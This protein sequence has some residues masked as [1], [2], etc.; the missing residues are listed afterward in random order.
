MAVKKNKPRPK[1]KAEGPSTSLFAQN[2]FS[3]VEHIDGNP[4]TPEEFDAT[5]PDDAEMYF[6]TEEDAD[7]VSLLVFLVPYPSHN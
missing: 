3:A 6:N 5:N 1:A 4:N 7:D 2:K